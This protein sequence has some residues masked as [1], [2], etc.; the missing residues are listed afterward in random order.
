MGKLIDELKEQGVEFVDLKLSDLVG[1]LH[2]ITFPFARLQTAIKQGVGFDG[3]SLGG[4]RDVA[5]SDLVVKP[6]TSRFMIDPFYER[7]TASFY[8]DIYE[9]DGKTPFSACPRNILRKVVELL[10]KEG[11]ADRIAVLPE[12]EFYLFDEVEFAAG[13][14]SSGYTISSCEQEIPAGVKNA[15]HVTPPT[16]AFANLRS[17][18]V[19][20][21]E[22]AGIE[23]KYH[24]HEVGPYAQAEIETAL[25]DTAEAGDAVQIV[26]YL[27]KNA[28]RSRGVYATFMPKPLAREAGS[29]MHVHIQLWKDGRNVFSS[30]KD[31]N[32]LSRTALMFLGG[33]IKHSRALCAFTNPTTNSYRRLAGGMEAP[34]R[35][36]HSRANRKAA[37][38][39]PG[40]VRG[41]KELRF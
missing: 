40:Y 28:A 4:F 13:T 30:E 21:I 7:P 38:R 20:L 14:T 11:V 35:V 23:V 19:R 29:G 6:D 17:E 12:F 34:S 39:I 26:K 25:L 36:F 3:S 41:A 9:P 15:Y 32:E 8:G 2:H 16:D 18:M 1:R 27:V 10:R 33:I 22:E 24:H 5:E 37:L 31:E